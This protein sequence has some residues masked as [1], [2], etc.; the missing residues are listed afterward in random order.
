MPFCPGTFVSRHLLGSV[1]LLAYL[2]VTFGYPLML[3]RSGKAGPAYPCQFRPCGCLT[4]EECWAGDCC[5]FTLQEKITWAD[6]QGVTV[7]Q[8]AREKADRHKTQRS[9]CCEAGAAGDCCSQSPT[10]CCAHT[11]G[12]SLPST[13][14]WQ[15]V[16]SARKCRG[17]GSH[18]VSPLSWQYVEVL[19]D[20][21]AIVVVQDRLA[22]VAQKRVERLEAP[23]LP[24]PR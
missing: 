23:P 15:C 4:A 22:D 9:T 13:L 3:G 17:E 2:L 19:D 20:G 7:P 14:S 18:A 5:C 21:Y 24:P 8:T 11:E 10:D 16:L 12:P 1:T 6:T